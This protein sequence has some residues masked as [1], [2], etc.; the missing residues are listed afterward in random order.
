MEYSGN[1][2][3][4]KCDSHISNLPNIQKAVFAAL[5]GFNAVVTSFL[6]IG[7]LTLFIKT[8]SLRNKSDIHLLSLIIGY[9]IVEVILS[10][11]TVKKILTENYQNCFAK[12]G[13]LVS[14]SGVAIIV[15]TYD[16]YVHI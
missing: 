3:I 9:V 11:V 8:P 10:P 2:T 13:I 6:N 14:V 5:F 12:L 4:H 1:T 16:R 15:I 7:M